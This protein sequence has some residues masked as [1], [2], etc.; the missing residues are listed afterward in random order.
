MLT[1]LGLT[2]CNVHVSMS[3]DLLKSDQTHQLISLN[4]FA[5]QVP[6]ELDCGSEGG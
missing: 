2:S 6:C 4:Q 1:S 3:V 5:D